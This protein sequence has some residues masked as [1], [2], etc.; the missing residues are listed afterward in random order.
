MVVVHNGVEADLVVEDHGV[1][2][3]LVVE[4]HEVEA[5]LVMEDHGAEADLV[6]EDHGVEAHLE[7]AMAGIGIIMAV[8]DMMGFFMHPGLDLGPSSPRLYTY[9]THSQPFHTSYPRL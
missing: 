1:E 3:D 6:V 5:D 7:V 2:A 4:T 8:Q 9:A